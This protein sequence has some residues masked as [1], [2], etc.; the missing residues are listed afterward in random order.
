MSDSEL[1]A[2]LPSEGYTIVEP[3]P[4]YAPVRTGA[5][6]LTE[7]PEG[8]SGFTMHESSTLGGM[9]DDIVADLPT[10]VP[11]VGQLAFMLSLIHI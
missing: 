3:P 6:K 10:D 7:A 2:L 9:A 4:G 11:G 8:E 5:H 1:D